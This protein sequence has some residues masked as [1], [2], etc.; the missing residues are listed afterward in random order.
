MNAGTS[1]YIGPGV[2]VEG[3]ISQEGKEETIVIAG[4][5]AG[6]IVTQGRVVLEAEGK[7]EAANELKCFELEAAGAIEG[8]D[9]LVEAGIF[10]LGSS[11]RVSVGEISLP[12]GGL[13]QARGS[14]LCAKLR[15]EEGNAFAADERLKTQAKASPAKSPSSS[16]SILS[17]IE[18]KSP[19]A[20]VSSSPSPAPAAPASAQNAAAATLGG[21][22]A[23]LAKAIQA[24]AAAS[25]VLPMGSSSSGSTRAD[26]FDSS[27]DDLGLGSVQS[28]RS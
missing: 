4:V 20:S 23:F 2:R 9:V 8:D 25:N 3:R 26:S 11:A 1:L 15:M 24:E 18:V 22:P 12:P 19:V 13:E 14:V 21:T 17:S 28:I 5:F 7:I 6:D 16:A 10:R 27:F